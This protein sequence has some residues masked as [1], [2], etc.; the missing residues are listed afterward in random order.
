MKK[1]LHL[2]LSYGSLSKEEPIGGRKHISY[3]DNLL[4]DIAKLKYCMVDRE[5]WHDCAQKFRHP[6]G[7][8]KLVS[9]L[10]EFSL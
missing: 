10:R 3:V 1:K 7:Q 9:E 4:Q 5:C 2:N 6:A 8:D